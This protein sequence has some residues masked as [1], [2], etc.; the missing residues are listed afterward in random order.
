MRLVPPPGI[1]LFPVLFLS[2][3]AVCLLTLGAATHLYSI[4]TVPGAT[5]PYDVGWFENGGMGRDAGIANR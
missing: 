2:L 4:V 1:R 3:P 5:V